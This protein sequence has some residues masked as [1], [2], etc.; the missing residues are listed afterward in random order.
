LSKLV[1]EQD[2]CDHCEWSSRGVLKVSALFMN[3][4]SKSFT[5]LVNIHVN[6]VQSKIAP[7]L[8]QSDTDDLQEHVYHEC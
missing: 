7:D 5:P 3:A 2:I 6:N 1:T 8:N 4:C